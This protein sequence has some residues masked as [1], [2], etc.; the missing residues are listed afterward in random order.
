MSPRTIYLS[1]LLGLFMLVIALPMLADKARAL[2]LIETLVRDPPAVAVFG[3]ISIAAGL[4]L[5]LGHQLWSGGALPV[6]VT[7]LGWLFLLRGAIWLFLSPAAF[8]S[9]VEKGRIDAFFYYYITAIA[10]LGLYL[11]LAGFRAA[12]GGRTAR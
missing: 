4:A 10:V 9:L 12:G 6:V 11:T 1:R 3:I 8:A 5:V 2:T 7:L